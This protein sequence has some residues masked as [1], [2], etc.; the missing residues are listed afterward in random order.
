MIKSDR[1]IRSKCQQPDG[2]VIAGEVNHEDK[3]N[4]VPVQR[5]KGEKL[6]DA[7][8]RVIFEVLKKKPIECT[9]MSGENLKEFIPMITPYEPGNIREVEKKLNYPPHTFTSMSIEP[10]KLPSGVEERGGEYF[11]KQKI[12]SYGTSSFGY[13]VTLSDEFQIFSNINNTVIDPLNFDTKCLVPF[14]GEVCTLPP[15]S[16]L[17]GV[18]REYFRIPRD[19][20]VICVGKSTYARCFTEDTKVMLADGSTPTF[21]EL[22]ERSNKGERLFGYSVDDQMKIVISEFFEPRKIGTEEVLEVVLDN[23]EVIECTPDHKFITREGLEIKAEDLNIGDSLFPLYKIQSRGYETIVQPVDWSLT[24]GHVLADDWN[25]RHNVYAKEENQHRHHINETR[26]DN[27]PV[28]IE[29]KNASEHIREHNQ[30]KFSDPEYVTRISDIQKKLYAENAKDPVWVE[31]WSKQCSDA[32]LSF[33]HNPEHEQSRQS[34]RQKVLDYQNSPEGLTNREKKRQLMRLRTSTESYK[35]EMSKRASAL[36]EDPEYRSMMSEQCGKINLREDI[37]EK[38]VINALE[39]EGSI[40][41][42]ARKLNC[43]KSVFRRFAN[44]IALFKEK[45]IAAKI[46]CDQFYAA[47]CNFGSATKAA[48]ALKISKSYVN[49]HLQD[50]VRKFYNNPSL[51]NNHK[52]LEIRRKGNVK[53]VYCLTAPE[54]GNFALAAGVF[55][56]NCGAIVNVTPIEPG[57]EGHVVI[58]IANTTSL[59]MKIY[60]DQGIAQFMFFQSDEECEVSYADKKGKYQG[61]TGVTLA[62]V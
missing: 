30:E 15:N 38:E 19:V 35:Q 45:W 39:S 25:L 49:R 47:M 41:G 11:H 37:T 58:E 8:E 46:T 20:M 2:Y 6:T 53:D 56:N 48:E 36:W 29:R 31:K 57:F 12:L 26:S 5:H 43:D 28:N 62:K 22:V 32:A 14:K 51:D 52:V 50:A 40:R 24:P 44:T 60:A 4:W 13:D 10:T 9:F 7:A 1:W 54:H 27:R 55:V 17:L 61:Q 33:W 59:P 23:G 42:A 16:Y 3:S 21:T 18:T 34:H